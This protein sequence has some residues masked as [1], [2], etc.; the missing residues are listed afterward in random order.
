M[1]MCHFPLSSAAD[2]QSDT[3][4]C[5]GKTNT[6]DTICIKQ[7]DFVL[8]NFGLSSVSG[9]FIDSVHVIDKVNLSKIIYL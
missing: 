7:A 6:K 9:E 1:D 4:V 3:L 8:G 5:Y 2:L